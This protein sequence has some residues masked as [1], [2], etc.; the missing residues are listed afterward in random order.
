MGARGPKP[1][2]GLLLGGSAPPGNFIGDLCPEQHFSAEQ[3]EEGKCIFLRHICFLC[4]Y[5]YA[6]TKSQNC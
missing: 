4:G 1:P 3:L 2:L 5:F 6:S